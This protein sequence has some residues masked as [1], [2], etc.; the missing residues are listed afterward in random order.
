MPA[1][2]RSKTRSEGQ[3]PAVVD[4]A[5][6]SARDIN[7]GISHTGNVPQ[8]TS[9]TILK[10]CGVWRVWVCPLLVHDQENQRETVNVE[11]LGAGALTPDDS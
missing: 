2:A 9:T 4:K 7:S 5:K 10:V 1:G 8:C 6:S 11:I 3:Y